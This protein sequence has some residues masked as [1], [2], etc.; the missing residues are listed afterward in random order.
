MLLKHVEGSGSRH[1]LSKLQGLPQT[2]HS[3][4]SERCIVD[5]TDVGEPACES[6]QQQ[7]RTED[8]ADGDPR[9]R[10]EQQRR[11][12][13]ADLTIVLPILKRVDRIVSDG[14][15][16]RRSEQA[17][18]RRFNATPRSGPSHDGAPAE[19][20][21]QYG[22]RDVD[23]AFG[24]WVE[25]GQE[26]GDRTQEDRNRVKEQHEDSG[27][28]EEEADD[29]Q[30]MSSAEFTGREWTYQRARHMSIEGSIR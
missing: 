25:A 27:Q 3:N 24:K 19:G 7:H 18:G 13:H 14:P 15:A 22:L 10:T 30:S 11:G 28:R 26:D 9:R 8:R 12:F 17:P 21:A 16:D 1:G 2:P 4:G 5:P 20:D 6:Q 29:E 23:D